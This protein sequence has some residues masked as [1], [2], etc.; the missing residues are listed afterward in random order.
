MSQCGLNLQC[1]SAVSSFEGR[2]VLA[3]LTL[4]NQGLCVD[5]F[6]FLSVFKLVLS[7][8]FWDVWSS[9]FIPTSFDSIVYLECNVAVANQDAI[10]QVKLPPKVKYQDSCPMQKR[11]SENRKGWYVLAV[12]MNELSF[13]LFWKKA[14]WGMMTV[15]AGACVEV[16]LSTVGYQWCTSKPKLLISEFNL[17]FR[18]AKRNQGFMPLLSISSI[19]FVYTP[20]RAGCPCFSPSNSYI[21]CHWT[22]EVIVAYL[23]ATIRGICG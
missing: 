17:C 8:C 19:Q 2:Y 14:F 9:F 5:A 10:L 12:S 20:P 18:Y 16:D 23:L 1:S 4:N 3:Y 21:I 22:S 15:V 6:R 11:N 7:F 13:L